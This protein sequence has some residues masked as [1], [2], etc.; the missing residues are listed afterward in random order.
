MTAQTIRAQVAVIGASPAGLR[1]AWAAAS[2]GAQVV[3]LEAR[4]DVGVPEPLAMVAFDHLMASRAS[5]PESCIRTRTTNLTA[6]SPGGHRITLD[7]P[8]RILDRTRFDRHFLAEAERAGATVRLGTGPLRLDGNRLLGEQLEVE[9]NILIFCDGATSQA[10]TRLATLQHPESI[11]WGAAH[12][13]EGSTGPAST[14]ELRIGSHARGGRTQWNPLGGT[15]WTHWSFTGTSAAE[16]IAQA[17]ANL[18]RERPGSAATLLGAAPDPVYTLPGD[19]VGDGILVAGGAAGQGGL[20]VGLVSGEWAGEAAAAAALA[21]RRDAAALAPYQT[22]WRRT[23]QAGYERLRDLTMRTAAK[24]DLELDRLMAPL[25]G[26]QVPFS[27]LRALGGSGL[28]RLGAL[29]WLLRHPVAVAR[30]VR[31]F[32]G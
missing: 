16:A 29:P 2:A 25:D 13:V 22:R 19:L 23:Y 8:A 7:A 1:A 32:F 3:L 31:A 18:E 17:R 11:V 26:E 10:R 4:P 24:S 30:A 12:R 9:A 21:G 20:E 15:S 28:A 6:V 14:I 27:V 5:P